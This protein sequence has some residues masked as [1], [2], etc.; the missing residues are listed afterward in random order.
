M[1]EYTFLC[2]S[3]YSKEFVFSSWIWSYRYLFTI[4]MQILDSLQS[5]FGVL[6][7]DSRFPV[8]FITEFYV[9]IQ[10][11]PCLF[12]HPLSFLFWGPW[13]FKLFKDRCPPLK[14]FLSPAAPRNVEKQAASP[15]WEITDQAHAVCVYTMSCDPYPSSVSCWGN[16]GFSRCMIWRKSH[17]L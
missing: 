11:I 9:R 10:S 1:K 15:W 6:P 16:W 8:S 17:I 7:A 14:F 2:L 4:D 12:P 5:S 3:H 13:N